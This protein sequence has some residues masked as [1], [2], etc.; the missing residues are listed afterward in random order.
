MNVQLYRPGTCGTLHG[1]VDAG[2][3]SGQ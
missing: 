2:R 1:L 3:T